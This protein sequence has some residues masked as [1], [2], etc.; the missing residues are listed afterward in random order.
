MGST[1]C[2]LAAGK[3]RR[4]L[5][6]GSCPSGIDRFRRLSDRVGDRDHYFSGERGLRYLPPEPAAQFVITAPARANTISD[7]ALGTGHWFKPAD[8][9]KFQVPIGFLERL[10]Q[11][12]GQRVEVLHI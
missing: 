3:V 6:N 10:E 1:R 11:Q 9:R 12:M 2:D 5:G 4:C 8:R 7:Q